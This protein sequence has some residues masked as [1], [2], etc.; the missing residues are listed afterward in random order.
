MWLTIITTTAAIEKILSHD[1]RVGFIA[2]ARDLQV[3]LATGLLAP[4][5]SKIAAQ[6][7]FNFYVDA[8]LTGVF[9]ALVWIIIIDII[10]ICWRA[11]AS[12]KIGIL[13]ETSY[14]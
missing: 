1:L 7:I 11:I 13:N 9:V 5:Q 8:V 3:K 4:T 10:R 6:L 12:N 14:I 2:A